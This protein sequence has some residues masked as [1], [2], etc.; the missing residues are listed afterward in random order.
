[1]DLSSSNQC[2]SRVNCT[3]CSV[4]VCARPHAN[5]SDANYMLFTVLCQS[6]VWSL[7]TPD[8]VANY[9]L[10][11]SSRSSQSSWVQHTPDGTLS[12]ALSLHS[13]LPDARGENSGAIGDLFFLSYLTPYPSLIPSPTL[14]PIHLESI[15][16]L[17]PG[18]PSHHHPLS[19]PLQALPSW[20]PCFSPPPTA[21]C[22]QHPLKT[23]Q[24]ILLICSKP[25]NGSPFP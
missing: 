16:F 23:S 13:I 9:L 3:I 25:S 21:G 8:T 15:H 6:P 1:M 7:S 5:T 11:T 4:C 24:I 17:P 12:L 20:T 2:G 19:G 14:P 10:L 22:P 18:T